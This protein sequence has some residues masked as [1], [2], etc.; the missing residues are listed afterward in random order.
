MWRFIT[1]RNIDPRENRESYYSDNL[2]HQ[3][4]IKILQLAQLNVIH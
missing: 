4:F 1:P 3:K 2:N